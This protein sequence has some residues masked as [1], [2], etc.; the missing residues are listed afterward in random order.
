MKT[1]MFDE[2]DTENLQNH[3]NGSGP[4]HF[5]KWTLAESL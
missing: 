3:L 2:E 5:V 1:F 4:N